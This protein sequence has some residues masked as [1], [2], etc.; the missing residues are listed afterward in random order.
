MGLD[1]VGPELSHTA[2]KA[3]VKSHWL[4]SKRPFSAIN[5]ADFLSCLGWSSQVESAHSAASGSTRH[6]EPPSSSWTKRCW[7]F[8]PLLLS[9]PT[10]SVRFQSEVAA[11]VA[12]TKRGDQLLLSHLGVRTAGCPPS[13]PALLNRQ[14]DSL[15][16]RAGR[17]THLCSFFSSHLPKAFSHA[18]VPPQL[19]HSRWQDTCSLQTSCPF[20]WWMFFII[21]IYW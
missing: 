15:A 3:A 10:P 14:T 5:S 8:L 11:T 21:Q 17:A 13:L 4:A 9:V 19:T 6:H 16:G 12:I 2:G 18:R 1:E 7:W 20:G